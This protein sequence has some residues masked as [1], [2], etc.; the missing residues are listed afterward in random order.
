[1]IQNQWLS[2]Y[3]EREWLDTYIGEEWVYAPNQIT[4]YFD[5][6]VKV[7]TQLVDRQLFL[8]RRDTGMLVGS[9]ISE[10]GYY[11]IKTTY[12][13]THY[14]VCLDDPLGEVFNDLV[15]GSILPYISEE[16]V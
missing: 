8:H 14:L 12:S 3:N 4:Y 6:H 13:G 10:N 11:Y 9:D 1:M 15:R 7:R 5:G 16:Y 2:S